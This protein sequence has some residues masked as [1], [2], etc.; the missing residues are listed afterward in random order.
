[1]GIPARHSY[2]IMDVFDSCLL[3]ERERGQETE[4]TVGAA[5]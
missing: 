2:N 3:A 4:K 1:M 5:A